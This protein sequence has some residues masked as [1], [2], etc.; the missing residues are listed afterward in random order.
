MQSVLLNN[1]QL[2]YQRRRKKRK[3]LFRLFLICFIIAL[4]SY[5][6]FNRFI[7]G[8]ENTLISP[9]G[10]TLQQTRQQKQTLESA[11]TGALLNVKGTYAV[12]IKNLETGESFYQ[13]QDKF[14]E[15]GSLYKLWV[16]AT[17]FKQIREGKLTEDQVLTQG[18]AALNK[19]FSI[20]PELA[21]QTEGTISLTVH[22]ALNQMITISHNYAALLLTEKIRLSS[23]AAFV[24]ENNLSNSAVGTNGGSPVATS[25]DI[26]LFL[27]KLYKGELANEQYTKSMLDLL[28]KQQLNGGLSKYLPERTIVAHKTGEIGWYK[29]DAG[30]VYTNKGN[31][32]IVIMSESESPTGAQERIA[33][34]SKTVYEYFTK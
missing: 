8:K 29:H 27:E 22:D 33:Q 20:D 17:V 28:K 23:V 3:K 2:K 12:A 34:I 16:M 1:F 11:V 24:K 18:I 15:A 14:F 19:K 21:E 6:M 30:I 9:A 10:K 5:L 26:A 32:I 7:Q 13:N 31:Y 25:S 4:I